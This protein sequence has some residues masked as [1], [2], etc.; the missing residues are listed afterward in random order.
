MC[1]PLRVQ[2][3][4]RKNWVLRLTV[5]GKLRNSGLGG[6]PSVSLKAARVQAAAVVKTLESIMGVK[7]GRPR[8]MEQTTLSSAAWS[9]T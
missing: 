3:T 9:A 4:G 2:A 7:V 1:P 8:D 6:Y 5:D